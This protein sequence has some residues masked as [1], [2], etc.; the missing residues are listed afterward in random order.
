MK[1]DRERINFSSLQFSETLTDAIATINQ[2]TMQQPR[3]VDLFWPDRQAGSQV[4]TVS[5]S[6]SVVPL[7]GLALYGQYARQLGAALVDLFTI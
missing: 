7:S 4:D 5:V 2:S 1:S 6:V 3:T